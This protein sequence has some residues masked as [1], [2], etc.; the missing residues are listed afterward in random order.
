MEVVGEAQRALGRPKCSLILPEGIQHGANGQWFKWK[1]K[2]SSQSGEE[3][4]RNSPGAG[5]ERHGGGGCGLEYLRD[6]RKKQL[7]QKRR[8]YQKLRKKEKIRWLK[9]KTELRKN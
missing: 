5:K 4:C 9:R 7:E 2:L 1:A 8:Y 6:R 3:L